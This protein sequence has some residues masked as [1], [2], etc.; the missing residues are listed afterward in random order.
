MLPCK[1]GIHIWLEGAYDEAWVPLLKRQMV[2]LG[3]E[4]IRMPLKECT[5]KGEMSLEKTGAEG[6]RSID[7]IKGSP[8][9]YALATRE[10]QQRSIFAHESVN[11]IGNVA[12]RAI[13]TGPGV[14]RVNRP[15]LEQGVW[16]QIQVVRLSKRSARTRGPGFVPR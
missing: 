15:L 16:S 8:I 10:D 9:R 1:G 11:P 3:S 13:C 4:N 6:D 14:Y 12:N 2:K 7:D 5:E